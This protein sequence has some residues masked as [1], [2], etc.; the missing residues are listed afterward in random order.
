M[1]GIAIAVALLAMMLALLCGAFI[2]LR[3]NGLE[4]SISLIAVPFIIAITAVAIHFYLVKRKRKVGFRIRFFALF[5]PFFLRITADDVCRELKG[6][7]GAAETSVKRAKYLK[8]RS[9]RI[10]TSVSDGLEWSFS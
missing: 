3:E 8:K 2:I 5:F 9:A 10:A 7:R 4:V 1:L 6:A